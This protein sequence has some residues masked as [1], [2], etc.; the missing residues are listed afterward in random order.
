MAVGKWL[1]LSCQIRT[2]NIADSLDLIKKFKGHTWQYSKP[3]W[4]VQDMQEILEKNC[5]IWQWTDFL[6]S[7]PSNRLNIVFPLHISRE[8]EHKKVQQDTF[9]E[10]SN[11]VY[12]WLVKSVIYNTKCQKWSS[13]TLNI[14]Q[15]LIKRQNKTL[16][17][18]LNIA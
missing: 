3:G 8:H 10:D 15:Y 12:L 16:H 2:N 18:L 14:K 7:W 13:V 5:L 1:E 11:W 4:M 17:Y 6:S 9:L